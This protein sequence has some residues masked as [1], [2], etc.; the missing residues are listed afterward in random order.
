M[1]NI[2]EP[3]RTEEEVNFLNPLVWAYIGDSV[4]EL[5]IRT[6]L[7]NNSN[8]KVHKLHVNAVKFVKAAGQA[9]ILKAIEKELTE[10]EQNIVRRTRNTQNHH[11]AKN[12]TPA[13]YSYATAFEGL[14]GY[15]YLNKRDERLKYILSRALEE[16]N[17]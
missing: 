1:E 3:K 7:V 8:E 4:Y 10:E 15:L 17:K 6:N 16:G 11:I 12:A 5:F 9:K 14:I 13:E 2:I